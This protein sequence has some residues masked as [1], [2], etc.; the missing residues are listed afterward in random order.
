MF[1]YNILVQERMW[2]VEKHMLY[3]ESTNVSVFLEKS[4]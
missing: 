4:G 3:L 1:D 2:G